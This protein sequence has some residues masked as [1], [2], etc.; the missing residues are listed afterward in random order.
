MESW[1][2][3]ALAFILDLVLGDPGFFPHPIR[4]MGKSI[5]ALE[6]PFRSLPLKFVSSGILF[7]GVLIA[8]TW[9]FCWALL[10]VSDFFNPIFADILETVLIYYALSARSLADSAMEV[11][12]PLQNNK[13]REARE[14][15]AL[16]VGRDTETLDSEKISKAA[17][18]SVAE[19]LVDGFVS[20]LFY[21]AIGGAPL[22]MAFKMVNTLDS[23]IGYKNQTYFLFGKAAARIDDVAN[24]IPS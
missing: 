15:V 9:G 10:A 24:F 16:I 20:P 8:G 3:L 11:F 23:M 17:I 12:K 21:A 19:N 18:E 2:M 13:L 22:A 5:S 4:W 6:G 7:S 14:K 1:E